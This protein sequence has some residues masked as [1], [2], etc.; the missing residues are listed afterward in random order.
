[1][2]VT[3]VLIQQSTVYGMLFS[4]LLLLAKQFKVIDDSKHDALFTHRAAS[5]LVV[6]LAV[7]GLA[8]SAV[9]ATLLLVNPAMK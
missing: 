2:F 3:C 4:L 7:G 6:L 9:F 5:P 1:M 8:V